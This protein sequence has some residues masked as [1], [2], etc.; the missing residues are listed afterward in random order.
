MS[1]TFATCNSSAHD[2]LGIRLKNIAQRAKKS[3][4]SFEK[5][6][7][8]KKLFA[9][10]ITSVLTYLAKR[11]CTEA[12]IINNNRGQVYA[13]SGTNTSI[14]KL[15]TSYETDHLVS[16]GCM[17]NLAHHFRDFLVENGV[18]AP[19]QPVGVKDGFG[20]VIEYKFDI[21]WS[22]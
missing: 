4:F 1:K 18:A 2:N 17:N 16:E 10:N 8:L 12:T 22:E 3:E 20:S 13:T 14:V 9:E 7:T 5:N 19:E 6:E 11:G 21:Q 15:I